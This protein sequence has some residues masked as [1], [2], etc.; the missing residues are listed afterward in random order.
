MQ[1]KK[2]G[3]IHR[4]STAI[5][6]AVITCPVQAR[7][8]IYAEMMRGQIE[9]VRK[10]RAS[11]CIR[12]SVLLY[13]S[14]RQKTAELEKFWKPLHTVRLKILPR[15]KSVTQPR[16]V[17]ISKP[18]KHRASQWRP[19]KHANI[20]PGDKLPS[21]KRPDLLARLRKFGHS[22]RLELLKCDCCVL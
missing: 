8:L 19:E 11:E 12:P 10:L 1:S 18:L 13:D 14:A 5:I 15:Y 4:T 17:G 7:A 22:F 2:G 6:P 3:K 9:K 21:L 20:T 16:G